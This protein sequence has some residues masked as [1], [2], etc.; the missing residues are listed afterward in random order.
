ML[1]WAALGCGVA[2]RPRCRRADPANGVTISQRH[3][4]RH[5][6]H[7]VRAT[8]RRHGDAHGRWL[9]GQH[10]VVDSIFAERDGLC[11]TGRLVALTAEGA[12]A[13]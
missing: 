9:P 3:R 6:D 12:E 5:G 4:L 7:R 13:R 2:G 10:A 8:R 1:A 11:R